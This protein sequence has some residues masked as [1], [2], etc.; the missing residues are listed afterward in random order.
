LFADLRH[1]LQEDPDL[2]ALVADVQASI[3]GDQWC[4]V[5]GLITDNGQGQ[6]IC[7]AGITVVG[8][9]GRRPWRFQNRGSPLGADPD[10]PALWKE[11]HHT[12]LIIFVGSSHPRRSPGIGG[13]THWRSSPCRRSQDGEGAEAEIIG[14]PEV[15][16]A[17]DVAR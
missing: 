17:D 3:K 8:D 7:V 6:D 9:A 13:R 16:P 2:Q 11:G 5:D 12:P 14:V 1:E 10:E 4:V 15:L